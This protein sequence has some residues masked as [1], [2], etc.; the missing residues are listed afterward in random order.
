MRSVPEML[1]GAPYT[2]SEL[3]HAIVGFG[4][5]LKAQNDSIA[6]DLAGA[7]L[8]AAEY[9]QAEPLLRAYADVGDALLAVLEAWEAEA[10]ALLA[11]R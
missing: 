11:A 7:D 3:R 1:D 5:L 10:V 4:V 6:A 8:G 2:V 9:A